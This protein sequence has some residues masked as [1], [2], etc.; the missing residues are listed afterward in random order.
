[1]EDLGN[2]AYETAKPSDA[3]QQVDFLIRPNNATDSSRLLTLIAVVVVIVGL[4]FGRQVLIPL[5]LATVLAFLLAPVVG[6]LEKCRLG[7]VPTVVAVLVLAV[8]L[9]GTVGWIVSGQLLNIVEQ[10]PNYKSNIHDRIQSLRV[11]QGSRLRNATNTVTE[12]SNE[13]SAASESAVDKKA[14]KTS[15]GR[16][17]TVQVTQP[18]ST[19]PQYLRTILGP[20]TGLIETCVIVIV[21]TLFMLVKREDLRNRVIRLA[22]PSQLNVMTQALDDASR[23][24]SRYLLLQ[25]LVNTVYGIIVGG[26]TYWLGIPHTLLW[27]VLGGLSR[28]VPYVGVPIAAAFPV[29]VALALFPGWHQAALIFG[30][31]V[32]LELITGNVVEPW[33]YGAHTGISSLAILVAAVFWTI[34]WGPVG[35][36]LS[37]P[38]TVCIFL[39]GRYVPQL[40]FLDVLLGDEPGLPLEAQ[41]YQRLLARDQDEARDIA[42]VYL[43]EKPVGSFY[44]SVLIPALAL[45]EQDRHLNSLE[46]ETASFVSQSVRELIEELGERSPNDNEPLMFDPGGLNGTHPD[47][48]ILLGVRFVCIP[49]GDEAD[50]LVAMMIGQLLERSGCDVRNMSFAPR[51]ELLDEMADEMAKDI[52]HIAI[53]SALPPFAVGQA[54]SL[55]KRLRQRHPELKIVLGLWNFENGIAKGQERLGLGSADMIVTSLQQAISVLA[56]TNLAIGSSNQAQT[57]SAVPPDIITTRPQ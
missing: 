35:L 40:S 48:A 21:F 45:A 18:P 44:D 12:L 34:L 36:I 57:Q 26:G 10:F 39:V 23:R 50:E 15:G 43:K 46:A 42:E 51:A 53:V 55:C 25:S 49:A 19:A 28:F 17:L 47:N 27:G 16:P 54:R 6:W 2:Q 56:E 3:L 11:S 4:Y 37:T 7:R 33:L 32:V 8:A 20:L 13:L 31:F 41:F 30:L 29:A 52:T 1:L 14:A 22:G 5:A 9:A 24:L 38:L